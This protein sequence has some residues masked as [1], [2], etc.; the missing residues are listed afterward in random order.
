[1][2]TYGCVDDPKAIS[3]MNF[4]RL[5]DYTHWIAW[6]NGAAF[7]ISRAIRN[8]CTSCFRSVAAIDAR[9]NQALFPAAADVVATVP[10]G[11][12]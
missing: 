12:S 1:M 5:A 8:P 11:E 4:K 3:A 7:A 2:S 10:E 6:R 9:Q